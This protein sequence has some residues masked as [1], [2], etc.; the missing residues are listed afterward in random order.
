[1]AR[2][3]EDS[4]DTEKGEMTEGKASETIDKEEVDELGKMVEIQRSKG[5]LSDEEMLEES[6]KTIRRV[7]NLDSWK[8]TWEVM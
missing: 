4:L 5:G 6:D 1:M 7:G 8:I 2:T 3:L